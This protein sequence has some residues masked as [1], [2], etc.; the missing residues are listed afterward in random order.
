MFWLTNAEQADA[1]LLAELPSQFAAYRAQKYTV[2]IFRSGSANLLD[3]T[4][5]LLLHSQKMSAQ[6]DL[7]QGAAPSPTTPP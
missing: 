6:R 1:V 4:T 3:K 5:G 7:E 2:V